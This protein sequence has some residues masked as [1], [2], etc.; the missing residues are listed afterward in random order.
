MVAGSL[1]LGLGAAFLLV[2]AP[3]I[4]AESPAIMGA[5]LCGF[6]VGWACLALLTWRF[7]DQPQR[8]AAAPAIFMGLSGLLLIGFGS[9]IDDVLSWVWPPLLLVLVVWMAFQVR[10]CLRSR[11]GR[12]LLYPVLTVLALAAVGGGWQTASAAADTRDY[13]PPGRLIDVSGHR[14]HLVCTGSGSP[15]VILEAGAGGM[16]SGFGWIAPAVARTTRVCAYDRAGHG[17]SDPVDHSQNAREIATDLHE[18]LARGH[19]PGPYVLAGHSFGGLYALTFAAHYPDEVAGMVLVDTTAPAAGAAST[20]A[21]SESRA[22]YSLVDRLSVLMA[23]SAR[24]GVT[25]LIGIQDYRTLPPQSAGENRATA[26]REDHARSTLDE[27]VQASTSTHQAA[28]LTNFD[29]KPLVVLT[30]G[31]GMRDAGLAAHERLA[32]L[33]GKSAH[34]VVE[35]ADHMGLID[36]ES[37]AITTTEAIVEVVDSVRDLQLHQ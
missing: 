22:S 23:T 7:T 12:W 32:A 24:V 21:P 27:Y 20:A 6:A 36:D 1:A 18:L 34:R 4:P 30:A 17:W 3:F 11:A 10:R 16:S 8:W 15:T 13:P 5:V 19:V 33:S 28:A 2:A 31:V 9:S 26:A 25:R 29:A 35:G 37:S 14:L